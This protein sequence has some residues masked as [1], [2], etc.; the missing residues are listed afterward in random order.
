MVA[1]Y[2]EELFASTEIEEVL[3]EIPSLLLDPMNDMLTASATP[4]K[5]F[6]SRRNDGIFL[7]RAGHVIKADILEL[8]NDFMRA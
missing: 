6:E 8:V 3:R 7:Q 1:Q 2:L 4:G 5:I